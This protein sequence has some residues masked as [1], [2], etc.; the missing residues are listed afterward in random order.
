M[1]ESKRG[2]GAAA[3]QAHSVQQLGSVMLLTV[4]ALSLVTS[5]LIV[6]LYIGKN[7]VARLTALSAG[8]RAIVSGRRDITIPIH[9]HDEITE[10][11]RAVEVFRGALAS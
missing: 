11:A 10:M 1:T 4:V 7:V 8:M 3:D 6:W 5:F 2:I 9:G